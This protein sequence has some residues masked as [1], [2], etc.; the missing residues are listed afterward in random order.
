M[1]YHNSFSV[2]IAIRYAL[3]LHK[4]I[5]ANVIMTNLN[6]MPSDVLET[7]DVWIND[8]SID[9]GSNPKEIAK[10]KSRTLITTCSLDTPI[11]LNIGNGRI[12]IRRGNRNT[13]CVA[14]PNK[15]KDEEIESKNEKVESFISKKSSMSS[16]SPLT[17]PF[18][19]L[20]LTPIDLSSS[21]GIHQEYSSVTTVEPK[22][23]STEAIICEGGL[24]DISSCLSSTSADD[25]IEEE[26]EFS[27][28]LGIRISNILLRQPDMIAMEKLVVFSEPS[29]AQK[30]PLPVITILG[31][32]H[33]INMHTNIPGVSNDGEHVSHDVLDEKCTKRNKMDPETIQSQE[34]VKKGNI[35]KLPKSFPCLQCKRIYKWKFN[36]NRHLKYECN[37]ENA[38]ECTGC[39]KRFPYKQNCIH[40]INGTH[41]INLPN[42]NQY[43]EEGLMKI[44]AQIDTYGE[45]SAKPLCKGD[46][47][48]VREYQCVLCGDVINHFQSTILHLQRDHKV[49]GSGGCLN[50]WE[51][52]IN[53]RY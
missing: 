17:S 52:F 37:K 22:D 43:I 2:V 44:H 1:I 30:T 42:N 27:S 19:H 12:K 41:H 3:V 34:N 26:S 13:E 35:S 28:S 51:G 11:P 53:L 8:H 18:T 7:P 29:T 49:S 48:G 9:L 15:K 25:A 36:L 40:H 38:F 23:L 14:I 20:Q 32:S 46:V 21:M 39:G 16:F 45:T 33:N 10:S 5:R 31:D 47:K 6:Q 24:S 50:F 4:K